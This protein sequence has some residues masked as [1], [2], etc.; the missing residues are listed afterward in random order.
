MKMNNNRNLSLCSWSSNFTMQPLAVLRSGKK[1]YSSKVP[2]LVM[3][4]WLYINSYYLLFVKY[5]S[6]NKNKHCILHK[7]LNRILLILLTA[8]KEAFK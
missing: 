5:S 4:A 8:F 7:Q 2:C 3:Y 6:P 1:S